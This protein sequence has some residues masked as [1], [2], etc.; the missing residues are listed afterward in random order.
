M[1][2]TTM[3][4]EKQNHTY[5]LTEGF[6][7]FITEVFDQ[8]VPQNCLELEDLIHIDNSFLSHALSHFYQPII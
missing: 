6:L 4:V 8:Q 1:Q 5:K 7:D 2:S 3:G